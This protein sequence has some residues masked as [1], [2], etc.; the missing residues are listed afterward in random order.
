MQSV[1]LY[2][3]YQSVCPFV[4]IGSPPTPSPASECCP[5]LGPRGGGTHSLAGVS[6]ST[7]EPKGGGNTRLRV[8]GR[9]GANSDDW[10]ESLALCRYSLCLA[11]SNLPLHGVVSSST[12]LLH[13]LQASHSTVL[14]QPHPILT[15]KSFK[16]CGQKKR[17]QLA[18][19]T[20]LEMAMKKLKHSCLV[21]QF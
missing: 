6:H 8:R 7:L 14:L 12:L 1:G 13:G 9:G 18:R 2:Q 5:H 21:V 10:R 3:E 15:C 16:T 19:V 11:L 17:I 4:Q 20:M